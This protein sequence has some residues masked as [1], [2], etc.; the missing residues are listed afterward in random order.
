MEKYSV[1]TTVYSK[2]KPEYLRQCLDSM[3]SQTVL[4]F[5]YIIV[6]DGPLTNELDEVIQE[7]SA[8]YSF[9]KVVRLK[10]NGGCGLA[11][12]AGMDA[13]TTDLVA[14]ID[15]DDI[16]LPNRCELELKEFENDDELVVVGS[17]MYEFENDPSVITGTKIMPHTN[18]E[19]YKFGKRRNPMNHSTVMFRKSIVLKYGGY[20]PIRRSLDLE[21][22]TKLVFNGCKC[23]NIDIPLIKFRTG[24]ARV[25]RKKNW[26]NLKCDLRVYKRN[27]KVGYISF[28]SYLYIVIRQ[29]VFYLLPSRLAS[30]LYKKM[31]R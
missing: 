21:L 9:F 4:P 6:E 29:F 31:Y 2:E 11:S 23:K 14:R 25:K 16:S 30:F 19:I 26:T 15:S 12:I 3:I 7:F 1:L 28:F 22:F 18:E 27:M 8:N 5:E 10:E 17:D 24:D 13:C 20:A